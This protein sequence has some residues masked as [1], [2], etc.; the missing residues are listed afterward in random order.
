MTDSNDLLT[1]LERIADALD[2]TGLR[3]SGELVDLG[4]AR[5]RELEAEMAQH[6]PRPKG[7]CCEFSEDQERVVSW[8]KLHGPLEPV[9][10]GTHVIVPVEPTEAAIRVIRSFIADYTDRD[11]FGLEKLYSNTIRAAQESTND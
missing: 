10:A 5:I 2:I 8:C 9:L 1:R 7:C 4:V 6:K 11:L 3:S